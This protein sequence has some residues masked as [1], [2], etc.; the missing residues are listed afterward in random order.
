MRPDVIVVGAG[1]AGAAT[2]YHLAKEGLSVT[3]IEKERPAWG[4]SGRNPGFLWLQT[5]AAGFPMGFALAGRRYAEELA[6]ELPDFGF[7]ASGGLIVYR[8]EEFRPLA[9]RFAADRQAAGLPLSHLNGDEVREI[10]PALSQAVSGALWNPLDAHQDTRR[11]VA[12][13]VSEAERKGCVVR[14]GRAA[15]LSMAGDTCT[16]I[17]LVD[18]ERI[19]AGMTI[20]AAGPWSNELLEQA[21]LRVPI[22]PIRFEAAETEP[23]PFRIGPVIC[24]QALFEFFFNELDS[25]FTEQVAQYED[26]SLQFGCAFERETLDDQETLQGQSLARTSTAENI[27]GFA[28]LAIKRSWAGIVAGTPDGLPVID[29]EPGPRGLGLNL[30]HF[31]G[32][33]VGGLSGKMCA[34]AIAGRVPSIDMGPLCYDRFKKL[35]AQG[36]GHLEDVER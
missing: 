22:A 27:D 30:G 2:A 32:N 1:V 21:G 25:G 23:A 19:G 11:L 9:E 3:L 6:K 31:F 14:C 17:E 12:N 8:D 35:G 18:G 16:G 5:K 13:F 28:A 33:L 10:C 34:D 36:D 7:R 24:G 15:R 20:V 29:M 26:G 4:A